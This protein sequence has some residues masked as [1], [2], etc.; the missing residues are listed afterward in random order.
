[1][2][3][4]LAITAGIVISIFVAK[5]HFAPLPGSR[6]LWVA[7]GAILFVIGIVIRHWAVL[8]LGQYF[9]TRVTILDEHRLITDGPYA[10][11]RNPSYS[12]AL[13]TCLGFGMAAGSL[14]AIA[15]VVLLPMIAFIYRI[16][17][18]EQALADHFGDEWIAYRKRTSALIPGIW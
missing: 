3:L 8:W 10:K 1:M 12:G 7:V 9:R 14:V 18:E 17:V 16:S 15:A 5:S 11:V 2:L 6:S 13:L 4:L